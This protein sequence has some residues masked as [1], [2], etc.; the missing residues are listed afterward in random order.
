VHFQ[1]PHKEFINKKRRQ[2]GKNTLYAR[3][4]LLIFEDSCIFA[5]NFKKIYIK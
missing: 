2:T 5:Q 3:I 1:N 4:Y